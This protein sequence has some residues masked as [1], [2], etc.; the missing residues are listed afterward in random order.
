MEMQQLYG[1]RNCCGIWSEIE[2][3]KKTFQM[4]LEGYIFVGTQPACSRLFDG[5]TLI[6]NHHTA[7]KYTMKQDRK[8]ARPTIGCSMVGPCF[9]F[10]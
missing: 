3:S 10:A 2:I 4:G 7:G 9:Q 6:G 5:R 1:V 8:A